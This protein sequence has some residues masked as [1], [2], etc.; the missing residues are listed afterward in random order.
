MIIIDNSQSN[1]HLIKSSISL[2][3]ISIL[4]FSI[5]FSSEKKK[6]FSLSVSKHIEISRL[7]FYFSV[8]SCSISKKTKTF[9]KQLSENSLSEWSGIWKRNSEQMYYH[10]SHGT[11]VRD[12]TLFSSQNKNGKCLLNIEK[13]KLF[14]NDTT[15]K[16]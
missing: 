2:I 1:L 3:F 4:P 11:N 7:I 12:N 5:H 10:G 13:W 6:L 8:M 14:W 16:T 15:K 9:K